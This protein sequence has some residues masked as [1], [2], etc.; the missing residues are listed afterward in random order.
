MSVRQT[1]LPNGLRIVSEAMPHVE[2]VSLGVWCDV[3]TRHELPGA[4]GNNGISHLLEHMAFKGTRRRNARQLAE[5]IEQVGGHM[6]AYTGREQTA[7]HVAMLADDMPLGVD[8]IGDILVEPAFDPA[9]LER[10]RAVILQEISQAH[11]TPDD[12]VFDRFQTTAFPDQPLG[13]PVLGTAAHLARIDRETLFAYRDRH[14]RPERMIAA[15]A[16]KV[17]HDAFVTEVMRH[18]GDLAGGERCDVAPGVYAGGEHR[19]ARALEQVHLVLGFESVGYHDPDVYAASVLAGLLGG[20]MSSRLFQEV[21]EER[22]LAY[23]IFAFAST[24]RDSGLL[25]VYAGTSETDV[26]ELVPVVLDQLGEVGAG[27][28][29]NEVERARNQL[30]SGMLM[31][32]ETTGGRCEQLARQL[33]I[34]ERIVPQEEL[35]A[36]IDAVDASA[37][38]R[39]ARRVFAGAPSLAALGP[40]DRLS[41]YET[42]RSRLAA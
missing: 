28:Q 6:N 31:A 24:Y 15:A 11:D 16:G 17:D 40:V 12:V 9:E 8:I 26:T 42:I 7:Y 2:T 22:G 27:V 33:A 35:V 34:F 29:E 38:A 10:E 13:L 39:V 14:Y 5:E 25:S 30:K 19:E 23:S 32:Q 20:G 18:F 41:D 21:R 1:T 36:Q 4:A 3:G 37:I